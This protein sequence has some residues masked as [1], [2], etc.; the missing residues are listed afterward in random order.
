M[1]AASYAAPW[2]PIPGDGLEA[3][4]KESLASS[5][6]PSVRGAGLAGSPLTY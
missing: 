4:P 1:G 2:E 5:G 3:S 6:R